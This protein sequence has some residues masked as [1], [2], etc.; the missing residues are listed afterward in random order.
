MFL[1][2]VFDHCNIAFIMYILGK[3]QDLLSTQWTV[4]C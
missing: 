2:Y 1:I 4:Q 3:H